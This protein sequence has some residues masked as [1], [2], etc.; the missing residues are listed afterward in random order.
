MKKINLYLF[1]ITNKYLFI[2]LLIIFSLSVFLNLI[3]ISRS[4][5]EENQIIYNYVSL[6]IL[7]FPSI[8]NQITPFIVIISVAF[9]F[10]YLI[11]N[12]ELTSMRN[13][14][15]S[16]IDIFIPVAFAILTFGL[17]NLLI[18]NPISSSFEKKYDEILNKK[19]QNIYSIRM[20]EDV[21]RIKNQYSDMGINYIEI[22]K[23]DVNKM[24]A[25][26]IKILQINENEKKLI[27]AK[28]GII[29]DKKFYLNQVSIFNIEDDFLT[30]TPNI[31]LNL[32][33][34]KENIINSI[35]N[36]KNI[37]F[38]EYF[39]HTNILKKFNLYSPEISLHYLSEILKPIFLVMLA[40]VVLGF[41]SKFKRNENFFKILFIA[42]FIGFLIFF[43]KEIIFKLTISININFFLSYMIIFIL[44]FLIGLYKVLQIEN[45]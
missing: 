44:P 6:S 14:G 13:I 15:Y 40:F 39:K 4:L 33:F 41:S 35:I 37:P 43:L 27:K 42:I 3:E 30:F 5:N 28:E 29:I 17:F 1:I 23:I 31:I 32:N 45:D 8:I 16:I 36:Y 21:M 20:S 2:N 19:N 11:N 26:N 38:Y 12:N 18:L 25:S 34:T 7:K 22:K 9:L 24:S 10:R